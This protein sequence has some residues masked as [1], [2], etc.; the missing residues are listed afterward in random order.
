[1]ESDDTV[2]SAGGAETPE[3]EDQNR[4]YAWY[5]AAGA[6]LIALILGMFGFAD[7][8]SALKTPHSILDVAYL[9][10]QLFL[11]ESGAV[12]S[13]VPWQ[14]NVARF[15]AP[16]VSGYAAIRALSIL[17]GERVN[18]LRI[19]RLDGHVVICGLGRQ[20]YMFARAFRARGD[21]VVVIEKDRDNDWIG[22]A[23]TEGIHVLIGNVRRQQRL[24]DAGI[25]RARH[26]IAI[27]EDDGVNA[28]VA[29]LARELSV[30][31]RSP[32]SGYAAILDRELCVLLRRQ[33]LG[34]LASARFRLEFFNVFEIGA[35]ALLEEFPGWPA[36][37]P[38]R[39]RGAHIVVAGLGRLGDAVVLNAARDWQSQFG[40]GEPRLVVTVVDRSANQKVEWLRLKF[41]HLT[42]ACDFRSCEFEFDSADFHSGSFLRE[43][44]D[45]TDLTSVYVCVDDDSRG[46][47]AGLI[48]HKCLKSETVPIIVR[49]DRA[50][51]LA[52]LLRTEDG[53]GWEYPNLHSFALLDRT[54][55]SENLIEGIIERLAR[56]IQEEYQR[57]QRE[58]G[59]AQ[60]D[61]P[62]M[63]DWENLPEVYKESNRDQAAH[64]GIKLDA[65]GCELES[66]SG[67]K[68]EEFSF[69]PTQ[70]ELLAKMEHERWVTERKRDDWQFAHGSKDGRR[71][72]SPYLVPWDDD[73]AKTANLPVLPEVIK[74]IDR[75]FVRA[76]PS[77]LAAAG[78][79]I[80]PVD[81]DE[82]EE[83]ESVR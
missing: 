78:Y 51:G 39:Q 63:R 2:R 34:R 40:R 1:M 77:V 57:Q 3:I 81:V 27:T 23:R 79:Q 20:G 15:L 4:S 52:T 26:L 74:D 11:F 35:R 60:E 22:P 46:L 80:V 62:A 50:G 70:I 28:E 58:S 67:W 29:S 30:G 33:Q 82:S 49:T 53:T 61:D 83:A 76:M 59:N 44:G 73:E 41:P 14:L 36:S 65:A 19:R 8:L 13:P 45:G 12:E 31:R 25:T 5:L 68:A 66:V 69:T 56:A 37:F 7:Q 17:F 24:L 48:L 75:N 72:T 54:C 6:G 38:G 64:T 43:H 18:Q 42:D 55:R 32:L 47:S 16:A 71:K 9:S 21:E 10:L